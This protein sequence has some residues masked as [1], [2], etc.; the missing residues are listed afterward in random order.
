MQTLRLTP[1]VK[2]LVSTYSPKNTPGRFFAKCK[3]TSLLLASSKASEVFFALF[4]TSRRPRKGPRRKGML[5][6]LRAGTHSHSP[7]QSLLLVPS[8]LW[9][10]HGLSEYKEH[11]SPPSSLP[12][13]LSPGV[14]PSWAALCV[15]H[16]FKKATHSLTATNVYVY[17]RR[18]PF[19]WLTLVSRPSLSSA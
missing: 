1:T 17:S 8:L 13:S 7:T 5:H 9:I 18:A 12:L 11:S 2:T 10:S 14:A 4:L 16:H 6:N 19:G 15:A 3:L